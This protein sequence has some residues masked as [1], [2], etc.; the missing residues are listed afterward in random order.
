MQRQ[1]V[2]RVQLLITRIISGYSSPPHERR[3]SM[4]KK[5]ALYIRVKMS[6]L[7][8]VYMIIHD[9]INIGLEQINLSINTNNTRANGLRQVLL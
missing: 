6:K 4:L 9:L 8:I 5:Q 1:R 7:I 2:K 3:L